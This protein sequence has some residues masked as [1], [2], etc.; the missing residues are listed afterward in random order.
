[1]TKEVIDLK[2]N[3]ENA[4]LKLAELDL[5]QS[6]AAKLATENVDLKSRLD[7]T[8]TEKRIIEEKMQ[9]MKES[10][11][12]SDDVAVLRSELQNVQKI[13]VED[14]GEKKEKQLENLRSENL[15][16]KGNFS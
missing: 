5:I 2:D 10:L 11:N 1:M 3:L 14:L 4:H 12:N 6:K 8:N 13:M 15:E 9:L 7:E 16:L